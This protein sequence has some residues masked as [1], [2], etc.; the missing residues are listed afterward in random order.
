MSTYTERFGWRRGCAIL[1]GL[2]SAFV[3]F[4]ATMTVIEEFPKRSL[5]ASA[6]HWWSEFLF[7]FGLVSVIGCAAFFGALRLWKAS[8]PHR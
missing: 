1:L 5:D 6:E 8:V 7:A 3:I 4:D 2:L